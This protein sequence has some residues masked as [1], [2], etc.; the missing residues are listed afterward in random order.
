[1]LH[2]FIRSNQDFQ[3]E[4]DIPDDVDNNVEDDHDMV[5][6]VLGNGNALKQWRDGIA[7]AMWIDYQAHVQEHGY[8]SEDDEEESGLT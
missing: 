3:D 2:N 4:Y 6:E 5:P 8:V 1:M 7:T